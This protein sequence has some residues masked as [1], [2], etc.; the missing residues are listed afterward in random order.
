MSNNARDIALAATTIS[1]YRTVLTGGCI[2]LV[3][4]NSML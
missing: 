2:W 3:S 4:S 1:I